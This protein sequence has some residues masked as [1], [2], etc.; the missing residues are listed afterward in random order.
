MNQFLSASGNSDSNNIIY[1]M[2][3]GPALGSAL[4]SVGGFTLPYIVVASMAFV[5]AVVLAF[6]VPKVK[7]NDKED[8]DVKTKTLTFSS[9][10]QVRKRME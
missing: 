1:L 7:T 5:M 8:G 2:F 3:L 6:V 9:L 4:Y 10:V